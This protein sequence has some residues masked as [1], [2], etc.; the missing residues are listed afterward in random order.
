[1]EVRQEW[2]FWNFVFNWVVLDSEVDYVMQ[3]LEDIYVTNPLFI[4]L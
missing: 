4:S 2:C 1:M 3:L